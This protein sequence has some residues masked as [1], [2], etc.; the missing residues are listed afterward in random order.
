[1]KD[2]VQRIVQCFETL[3]PAGVAGLGHVYRDD[4]R[5]ADPF[6]QV[7]GLA[8]IQQVYEHM[9]ATLDAPRFVITHQLVDGSQCFLV[10]DFSFCFRNFKRGQRQTVRGAS[11]L[12]LA[13]DGRIQLH[14]DYW[15]AAHGLYEKLP[16]VGGLM[17]WLKKRAG[18]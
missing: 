13:A 3:T 7:Q 11:H 17:R 5:F 6:N 12:V 8:A 4:A 10:W 9:Y 18:G 2:A 1:M 14:Q 15:D 16:V